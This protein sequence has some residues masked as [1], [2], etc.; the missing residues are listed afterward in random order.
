[1]KIMDMVKAKL[2]GKKRWESTP[3]EYNNFKIDTT[4]KKSAHTPELLE[5]TIGFEW[6]KRVFCKEKDLDHITKN[7]IIQINDDLYGELRKSLL[8]L[9]LF[10]HSSDLQEARKKVAQIYNDTFN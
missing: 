1:M 6:A 4:I 10:I 7:I 5:Y 3:L 8:E 9:E 2:T